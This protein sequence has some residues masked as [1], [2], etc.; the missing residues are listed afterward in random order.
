MAGSRQRGPQARVQPLFCAV[1]LSLSRF[2]GSDGMGGD[3]AA[4]GAAGTAAA[5]PHR[6]F[7]YKYSFKGPHLVQSDGTVPFWAH[8]GN[9]IPSSDQIR[10]APSLKSQ[11]G[12]VWTKTKAAFENWEV[13]VTFR[14]TGR[15]RIGADGLAVWYTENQ[16]LEGPVFGS[17]DMWNGVGIFFDSFDNDGKKNNPAIVIIGNNGQTHY[18]HQNDGINQ[19]LASCQRDF[20]NKPYPVRAKITYYQK[21]LMVMINN[22]FTPDKNDYEFCARVDNMVIPPQGHFGI[23]AATGG[24]ADDHDVLSFLTFQ[25]TEPGKELPTPDKEISEKEKEKYQ[26]EFEHFQQELDKKKEEFQKGHPDL[27]GHPADEIFESVGDRELRQIFEGQNR[28]HLEIKQLN[29]QLDMILDEQRRYVSSL[30]EEIAKRGSGV[31]GQQGQITQ[32]ELDTVVN[33]QHEI[34]RQVNEMKN[35]MSETVRLVSGIQHPGSAGGV[36]ESTQHFNDIKEH[37][38]IVKRDIDNLVQRNMPSN[39]RPK[40]PELPPFPSCLSTM[41]FVIFV[42]I[43]TVLFIGYIM[44]RTQQEAAAK[45]FF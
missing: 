4:A 36:Y 21:T 17:A 31:P 35:S 12:S 3:P 1:L 6:R 32:Q 41:H 42:V 44:Y 33:T 11:R 19:A 29:R 37:L 13:E 34:L 18:D 25:L 28:I 16:G 10:I 2:A 14:V 9:A 43:Q 8:A 7:E 5:S 40:C 22:G 20:R 27:Q 38:H 23:S 24:L 15:G 26:E 30:T 45:K 39:E